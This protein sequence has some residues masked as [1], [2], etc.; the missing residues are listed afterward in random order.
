MAVKI[1]LIGAASRTGQ[2]LVDLFS[3]QPDFEIIALMRDPDHAPPSTPVLPASWKDDFFAA[4]TDAS[5]AIYAA[6]SIET[7]ST[8]EEQQ[9]DRDTVARAAAY[10]KA[11]KLHKLVVISS[12]AAYWPERNPRALQHY[13]RMKREGDEAVIASNINYVILRPG[14]LADAP[15][16]GT[17]ALTENQDHVTPVARQDVAWAAIEAIKLNISQKIIGFVGGSV[18]I[19]QALRA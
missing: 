11:N 19:D 3:K 4:F 16:V 7:A 9:M 10:T 13:A 1:L 8:S 15:G 12:L 14:P 18:P 5:Y 2:A 17:I 6:G